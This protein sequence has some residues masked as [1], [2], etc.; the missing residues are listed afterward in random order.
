M[1]KCNCG[2]ASSKFDTRSWNILCLTQGIKKYNV[3]LLTERC[4]RLKIGVSSD[5][6]LSGQR[7]SFNHTSR[8]PVRINFV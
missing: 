7:T 4:K 8:G 1:T 2:A 6:P 5:G 3:Y